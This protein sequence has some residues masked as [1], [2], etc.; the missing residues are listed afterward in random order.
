MPALKQAISMK[1][2]V[3]L[4]KLPLYWIASLGRGYERYRPLKIASRREGVLRSCAVSRFRQRHRLPVTIEPFKWRDPEWAV[5]HEVW[6]DNQDFDLPLGQYIV[7]GSWGIDK[8][9]DRVE[10]AALE[11]FQGEGPRRRRTA[12]QNRRTASGFTP[13]A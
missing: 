9:F 11:G 1:Q 12:L 10:K 5:F 7:T 6:H 4:R 13:A 8:V 3:Y 2:S